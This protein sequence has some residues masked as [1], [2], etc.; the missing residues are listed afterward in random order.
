MARNTPGVRVG[1]IA[2]ATVGSVFGFVSFSW[3]LSGT[4]YN[5]LALDGAV[6]F[7]LMSVI[8]AAGIARSRM[9]L[10]TRNGDDISRGRFVH[11]SAQ[12][13]VLSVSRFNNGHSTILQESGKRRLV[14][15]SF[16]SRSD[17]VTLAKLLGTWFGLPFDDGKKIALPEQQAHENV[18][19][20]PSPKWPGQRP[21]KPK[22]VPDWLDEDEDLP[23]LY[24]G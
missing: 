14:I 3:H 6:I 24:Y 18:S 11:A 13:A 16:R 12:T 8:W 21:D 4:A 19:W 5:D 15:A 7:F 20:P 17:A 2:I 23:P 9:R 10:L 22:P 1:P